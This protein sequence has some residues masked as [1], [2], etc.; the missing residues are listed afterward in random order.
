MTS[1]S[2][3][4]PQT[5]VLLMAYGTP[6]R[7]EDIEGYYTNIRHGQRPPQPLYDQLLGRYQAIGLPSPL[8][9]ITQDQGQGLQTLL[10]AQSPGKYRVYVGLKYISPFIAEA[11]GQIAADGINEIIGLPLAPEYSS[12]SSEDYHLRAKAA[13]EDHPGISYLPVGSWWKHSDLIDF[14]AD[15]LIALGH[16][17]DR[18]DAM[19]IF[20]AHSLPM[21]IIEGGDPYQQ[22]V[23]DFME[24]IAAKADLPADHYTLAWQSAGRTE[25]PWIGPDFVTVAK[26][27]IASHGKKTIISASIGFISDNLEIS[28][29]VDI[30]LANAI[31]QAGGSLVRLRMPNTDPQLLATLKESV[32][33]ADGRS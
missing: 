20:S 17:T 5:A 4:S 33:E 25:E 7:E 9:K 18:D 15:Q 24:A 27:L 28:Y 14:W 29:D 10:D 22:E 30:E 1:T 26:D 19:V 11:V 31:R 13:L 2:A 23:I 3:S 8:A 6:Y 32:L 21:R 16:E 12:Y